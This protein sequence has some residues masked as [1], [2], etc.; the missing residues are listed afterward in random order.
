MAAVCD[1]VDPMAKAL[2]VTFSARAVVAKG[3]DFSLRPGSFA[4]ADVAMDELLSLPPPPEPLVLRVTATG[5]DA[6]ERERVEGD[7][8]CGATRAEPRRIP[9][10]VWTYSEEAAAWVKKRRWLDAWETCEDARWMLHAA[11]TVGVDRRLVVRAACACARTVLDRVP[12]G[13]ERPRRAIETAEAWTRGKA[14][15]DQVQQAAYA[16]FYAANASYASDAAAYAAFCAS[17]AS[18]AADAAAASDASDA[19]DASYAAAYAASNAASAR[20]RALAR[21]AELVR[22]EIATLVVLRAAIERTA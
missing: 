5:G 12:A 9:A 10:P 15:V 14:T 11:V 22:G 17:D 19:S 1:T 20:P 6:A 3:Y 2:R 7:W 21:L 13:E 18:Y 8:L 16:A 4:D